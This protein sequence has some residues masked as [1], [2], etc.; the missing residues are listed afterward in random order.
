[1]CHFASC[2]DMVI[3]LYVQ[4]RLSL[5]RKRKERLPCYREVCQVLHL[6]VGEGRRAIHQEY[7]EIDFLHTCSNRRVTARK[8]GLGKAWIQAF[9][10]HDAVV[11]SFSVDERVMMTRIYIQK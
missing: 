4:R 2:R 9:T 8:L 5:A 3:E 10:I 1:M 6:A 7:R 11:C